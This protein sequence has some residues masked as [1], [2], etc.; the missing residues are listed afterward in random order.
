LVV[1][2]NRRGM[3]SQLNLEKVRRE[4]WGDEPSSDQKILPINGTKV[5]A[6]FMGRAFSRSAYAV[7]QIRKDLVVMSQWHTSPGTG[8]VPSQ[9]LPGLLLWQPSQSIEEAGAR[10]PCFVWQ[11]SHL[12]VACGKWRQ[13]EQQNMVNLSS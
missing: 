13:G 6:V 5:A 3:S 11:I 4:T 10:C 1:V 9:L 7:W 12:S 2:W 8:S